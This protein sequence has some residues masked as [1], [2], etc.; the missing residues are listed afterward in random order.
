MEMLVGCY[1]RKVSG[2]DL[3]ELCLDV[4]WEE[5][6]LESDRVVLLVFSARLSAVAHHL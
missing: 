4:R 5:L 6:E 3:V 2:L 1:A